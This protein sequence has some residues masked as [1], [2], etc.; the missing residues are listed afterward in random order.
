MWKQC[1][2]ALSWTPASV[3]LIVCRE[4]SVLQIFA[5][6]RNLF[7]KHPMS[8]LHSSDDSFWTPEFRIL[9]SFVIK[10]V[11]ALQLFTAQYYVEKSNWATDTMRW[12]NSVMSTCGCFTAQS[13]QTLHLTSNP[14]QLRIK[15]WDNF[16]SGTTFNNPSIL[17]E[18]IV[19]LTFNQLLR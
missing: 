13:W 4:K 10:A 1:G 19:C 2:P 12:I 11:C 9:S 15:I 8:C 17:R 3:H 18:F 5:Q 14:I 7:A 6:F 16:L